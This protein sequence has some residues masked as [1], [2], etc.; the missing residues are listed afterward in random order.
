MVDLVLPQP[1]PLCINFL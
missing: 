1:I